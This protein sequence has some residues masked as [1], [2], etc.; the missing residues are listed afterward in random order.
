M[1][2]STSREG[3]QRHIWEELE[4]KQG[5]EHLAWSQVDN[6]VVTDAIHLLTGNGDA[7]TFGVTSDGGALM[8]S[9]LTGGKVLKSYFHRPEDA[10]QRL[11][12][13][14]EML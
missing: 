10:E 11:R 4:Q 12:G 6:E 1:A 2:V 3:G 7:V 8:V 9:L 13:V 14:R 5:H